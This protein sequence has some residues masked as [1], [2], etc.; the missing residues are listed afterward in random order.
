MLQIYSKLFLMHYAVCN[1]A[2]PFYI[3]TKLATIQGPFAPA[4]SV[5]IAVVYVYMRLRYELCMSLLL[6]Q[7]QGVKTSFPLCLLFHSI[8]MLWCWF[9]VY[10]SFFPV[11]L[12][13]WDV[14]HCL[15]PNRA[16]IGPGLPLPMDVAPPTTVQCIQPAAPRDCPRTSLSL[17]PRS[18]SLVRRQGR[19]RKKRLFI[20]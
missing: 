12:S 16:L 14:Y 1:Y 4:H 15:C 13:D 19:Q 6:R 18:S 9:F 5:W 11:C 3:F 17:F 20:Y 7:R 8:A 2:L 10:V